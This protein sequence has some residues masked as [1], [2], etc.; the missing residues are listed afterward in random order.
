MSIK[1][2]KTTLPDVVLIEPDIFEDQRGYFFETYHYH[3]YSEKGIEKA[4]V[5]DN[6][7]HSRKG[8][9]RGLH[10]QLHRPQAKLVY[11]VTGE[12]Y[13]VAVDIRRGSPTFGKWAGT[14]LS[15]ENKLQI[16]IPEG[17]AHGYC[18][19]SETADVIYKCTDFYDPNDSLGILWSDP[20]IGID[21]PLQTPILSIKDAK[22]PRL[23]DIY[24][25]SLPD[26]KI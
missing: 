15:A 23:N 25:T 12:I 26:Y 24:E 5:Q 18:V 20:S 10:Y 17:F 16:F 22:N 14:R 9:I 7:S 11:V 8:S 13:D 3:K 2:I 19:L 6:L 4:F 21:W 1:V